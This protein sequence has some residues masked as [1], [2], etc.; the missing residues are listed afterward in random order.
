MQLPKLLRR[1]APAKQNAGVRL[2]P[3]AMAAVAVVLGLKAVAMAEVVAETAGADHAPAADE[4]A[5]AAEAQAANAA[6]PANQCAPPT[7][8][9]MAGLSASE[10]QVL[11][12]LQ[13]RRQA[14]EARGEVYETQD[15]LM[16]AA[17]HRLNE[18]L[19]ELRQ[20]ETH[21]NDLLGQLDEAQEQRLASLVDV[22]QRMRAKDAAAVFDGLEDDVLV[23]VAS[24]MRQANLAEVMGRMS[25]ERARALT[26]MLADRARPPSGGDD[27]LARSRGATPNAPAQSSGR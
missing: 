1:K 17:E 5:A 6:A 19:A 3:A 13:A 21:V 18:R 8:A 22:Y 12:A 9:E 23:Q 10:V 15:E 20:L 16:L 2:M 27:L 11:Q 24:R 7:L 25:P 14:L 26:E 4:H